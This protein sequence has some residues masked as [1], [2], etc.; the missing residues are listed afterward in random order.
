M[1]A[2]TR[3][4]QPHSQGRAY[5][6][7]KPAEG[8]THREALSALNRRVSDAVFTHLRDRR[9]VHRTQARNPGGQ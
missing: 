6:D 4:R 5:Y 7:K 2:I 3:I 1:T 8:K 9:P